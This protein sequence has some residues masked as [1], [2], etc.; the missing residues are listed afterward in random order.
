MSTINP[1][2]SPEERAAVSSYRADLA[3]ANACSVQDR[4]A[5]EGYQ[6]LSANTGE[7]VAAAWPLAVGT[8]PDWQATAEP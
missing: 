2:S 7:F 5:A 3:E 6:A 8:W 1:N 4:L